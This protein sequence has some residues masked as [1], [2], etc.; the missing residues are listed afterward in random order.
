MRLVQVWERVINSAVDT[1][2]L[3]ICKK[4]KDMLKVFRQAGLDKDGEYGSVNLAFKSLRNDGMVGK[5]MSAIVD[6]TD[7]DLSI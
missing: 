6:L 3:E 2:N 5:L 4:V 1:G 7:K